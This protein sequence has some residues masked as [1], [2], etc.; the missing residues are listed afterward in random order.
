MTAINWTDDHNAGALRFDNN[1]REFVEIISYLNKSIVA[2]IDRAKLLTFID[3]IIALAARQ[4]R[5]E[6]ERF[7]AANYPNAS[8]HKGLHKVALEV[9]VHFRNDI[10]HGDPIVLARELWLWSKGWVLL[11]IQGEDR[12]CGA[13]LNSKAVCQPC[14]EETLNVAFLPGVRQNARHALYQAAA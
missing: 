6:E 4:F 9:L 14:E 8:T 5:H 2:G 3:N 7:V 12:Q 10:M 1:H 13:F 11:H